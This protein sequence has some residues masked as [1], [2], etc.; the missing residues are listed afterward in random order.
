MIAFLDIK[1]SSLDPHSYPIEI[2]WALE[3]G[4]GESWFVRPQPS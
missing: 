4:T 3:D 2:G 1:A